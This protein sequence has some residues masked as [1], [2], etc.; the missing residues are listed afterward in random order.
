MAE[1]KIH[2][3]LVMQLI[4]RHY[5]VDLLAGKESFIY[6]R[7]INNQVSDKIIEKYDGN[8]AFLTS[9]NRGTVELL[10]STTC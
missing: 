5:H 8:L 4:L 3:L 2:W 10:A 7:S 1:L 6:G 9:E